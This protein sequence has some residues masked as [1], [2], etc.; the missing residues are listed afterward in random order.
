MDHLMNSRRT[1]ELLLVKK[2]RSFDEPRPPRSS[3]PTGT[4]R[5][6]DQMVLEH[7]MGV[8]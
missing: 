5:T 7:L 2:V 4:T 3:W 6:L 1:F 8:K